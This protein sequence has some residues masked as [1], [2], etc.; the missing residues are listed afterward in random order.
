MI[1][2]GRRLPLAWLLLIKALLIGGVFGG[3]MA[4]GSGVLWCYVGAPVVYAVWRWDSV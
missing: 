4:V 1:L 2:T 3:C